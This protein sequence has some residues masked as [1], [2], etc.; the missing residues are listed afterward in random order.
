MFVK[1]F[2]NS[3]R[4]WKILIFCLV[5]W[6]TS[7][8]GQDIESL[9][10]RKKDS[11]SFIRNMLSGS[12]FSLTGTYGLSLRS[13]STDGETERQTPLSSTVYANVT[14]QVYSITI[15]FSFILNNLDDFSHPF[16]KEYFRG[17]LSNQRN[18]LSRLGI[19]PYYKWIKVHAGHRYMNFSNYTLSNHN[20]FG[21]GVE[22][23]PGKFRFAAMGGRLAKAEPVDLA[24]D[25]PNLPVYRRTGWG[26]KAGYGSNT[27]FID[28][29]LFNAKDDAGSLEIPLTEE[30]NIQPEENLVLAIKGKKSITRHLHLD[31]EVARSGHSRNNK[32]AR[33]E[34]AGGLSLDY[35]NPLFRRRT[36]TSYGNAATANLSYQLGKIQVGAG[37]QRID[38]QF[39]TFGAY[40]F[41]EDLENYTIQL[42]GYGI[43]NFSFTGSA[44]LQRNN[45][46]KSRQASYR[47]FISALNASYQVKT[48]IFGLNYSNFNSTI[49]YVLSK[50]YD[51]L[52]VVIVTSDISVNAGKSLT[53]SSGSTHNFNLRGGLQKVNQNLET[54]TGNPATNMYYTN[55]VY[56]LRLKSAWQCSINLDYNQNSLSGI[57]QDRYGIGGR[58]GKSWFKNKLDL[59]LGSQAYRGSSP[60]D[61]RSS[62]QANH[63]FKAHWRISKLHALQLQLNSI[64]NKRIT[65]HTAVRFSEF[66]ASIGYNGRFE[67]KPLIRKNTNRQNDP[68]HEK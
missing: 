11:T 63:S 18:R 57:R 25:R 26:F 15:P 35:N 44:G 51:S 40:F 32:D 17:M 21:A 59:S 14:A 42:S 2:E 47:R 49:N 34:R 46:D 31:F 50:E 60:G 5:A 10:N 41:N 39:R 62:S 13:Y 16:H 38:P 53:G 29:I 27:D 30:S 37:Y 54:P 65:D 55:F 28:L 9:L 66:I 24:L 6:N 43:R 19:S 22:L 1:V 20:F 12:P 33:V 56:N 4:K 58:I 36:S 3:L 7:G 48:W 67:Y 52:K 68:V 61:A 8:Y 45:L 23:T 64:H